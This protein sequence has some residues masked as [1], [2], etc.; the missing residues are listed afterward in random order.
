M[1]PATLVLSRPAKPDVAVLLRNA[2]GNREI[3][4][5]KETTESWILKQPENSAN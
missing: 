5:R 2:Q 3:V 4:E 1:G